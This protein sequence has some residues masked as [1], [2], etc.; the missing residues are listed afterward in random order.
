MFISL[1]QSHSERVS[2]RQL[3][4][5]F[6]IASHRCD[7]KLKLR[8][9]RLILASQFNCHTMSRPTCAVVLRV[10]RF[11]GL[12]YRCRIRRLC[13]TIF[14]VVYRQRLKVGL[15]WCDFYG[16][17]HQWSRTLTAHRPTYHTRLYQNSILVTHD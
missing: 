11:T 15:H 4:F 13:T 14:D 3:C 6:K 7:T 12:H 8:R 5:L 16:E 1:K 10:C 9:T 2:L 17:S